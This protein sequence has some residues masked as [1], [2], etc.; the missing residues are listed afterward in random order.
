MRKDLP[1][2]LQFRR[3]DHL[4]RVHAGDRHGQRPS[5][6]LLS[7]SRGILRGLKRPLYAVTAGADTDVARRIAGSVRSD[8]AHWAQFDEPDLI[9]GIVR[10]LV[11]DVR[12]G[13]HYRLEKDA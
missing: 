11:E 3:L 13:G 10:E 12:S 4:L 2:R 6:R 7:V 5:R 8:S 9:V 1:A